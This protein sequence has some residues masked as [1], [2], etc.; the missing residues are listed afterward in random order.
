MYE[1]EELYIPRGFGSREAV[2]TCVTSLMET[3]LSGTVTALNARFSS[4]ESS[5]ILKASS[6]FSPSTWPSDNGLLTQFGY[7]NINL[8][9]NHFSGPLQ[10]R[11]YKP[12]LCVEEWPELKL[13]VSQITFSRAFHALPQSLAKNF[14]RK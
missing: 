7:D 2:V 11:G 5:E 6:V 13:K 12:E 3:L 1:D 4:F 14:E 9:S 8:L 10:H